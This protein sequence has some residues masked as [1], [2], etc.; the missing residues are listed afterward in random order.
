MKFRLLGPVEVLAAAQ[1]LNLARKQREV[2]AAL[3]MD[4]GQSVPLHELAARVWEIPPPAADNALYAHLSRIRGVLAAD[5][6]SLTRTSRGYA[7]NVPR[8]WV[9]V[10]RFRQ[11][12]EEGHKPEIEEKRC[13]AL[14]RQAL[15]LWAATPLTGMSS[16]WA[17]GV[18]ES[19][20][21]QRITAA[22]QWARAQLRL[23]IPES[24]VTELTFLLAWR[25]LVEPLTAELMRALH[26]CGRSAEALDWF[27]RTR[28]H[29]IEELG[30]EPGPELRDL[31]LAILRGDLVAAP[32]RESAVTRRLPTAVPAQLP[33]YATD[34]TGRSE[35]LR[36]LDDLLSAADARTIVLCGAAGVGKTTLA[37]HWGQVSRERFS[38]G[39]LYVNLHGFSGQEPMMP[40]RALT[41]FLRALGVPPGRVPADVDEAAALFRSLLADKEV[42]ILLDN[43]ASADQVRPLLPGAA[44][45][46]VLITSRNRLSGLVA[47]DGARRISLD[48]LPINDAVALLDKLLGGRGAAEAPAICD[49]A[50]ACARLPLALRI[51]AARVADRPHQRLTDFVRALTDGDLLDALSVTDDRQAAVRTAF[52]A[53]YQA[54]PGEARRLFCM[55]GAFPGSH[56][57]IEAIAALA[58]IEV[59][60]A[61]QVLDQLAAMHMIGQVSDRRYALH[62]LLRLYAEKR[63]RAH[64]PEAER[65]A[66]LRRL[67]RYYLAKAD[68]GARK[69]SP[70]LSRREVAGAPEHRGQHI[71]AQPR[72][73]LEWLDSERENL[74]AVTRVAD[75]ERRSRI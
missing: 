32:G 12:I 27:A 22:T 49:L 63:C 3:L 4:A 57:T 62:G 59:A 55:A 21:Q 52:D 51:A 53:S 40:A 34:F 28:E 72:E 42:L 43:A 71:F 75:L 31:H 66:G 67:R 11:L 45:C 13:A 35:C 56:F 46:L 54:L 15:D 65:L 7:I 39:Q 36:E 10:F 38:D 23:G 50:H 5:R 30:T 6:V 73:A 37:V 29:L 24:V 60:R 19:L 9:D 20:E 61:G 74:V 14:L 69:V 47:G 25:P 70:R 16:I 18:R 64:I 58:G 41:H 26:D 2:L 8:D 33:A 48:V 17:V 44:G 1:P 68:P